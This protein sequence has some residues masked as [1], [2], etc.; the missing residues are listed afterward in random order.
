MDA[1][2]RIRSIIAGYAGYADSPQRR[3]SDEQVRGFVGEVLA[4]LPVVEIDNFSAQERSY[5]DRVLLRCEFTNQHV[6]HIFDSDP[7]PQ[8]IQAMLQADLE[9]VETA[10]TLR[11]KTDP[12]PD[13]VIAALSEAFDKRD[14]A[15]QLP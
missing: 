11:A 13:G 8:R 3:R 4:E 15:M 2:E 14:A 9:V 7:T 10:C 6:F 12:K 1:L 5:Y